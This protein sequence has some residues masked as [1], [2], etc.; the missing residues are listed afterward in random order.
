MRLFDNPGGMRLPS[1]TAVAVLHA[2]FAA[3]HPAILLKATI[4]PE[5]TTFADVATTVFEWL[6]HRGV[7]ANRPPAGAAYRPRK[8]TLTYPSASIRSRRM[9]LTSV[10]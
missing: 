2:R 3:N 4:E 10:W 1:G 9:R 6:N 8:S 7:P 5:E